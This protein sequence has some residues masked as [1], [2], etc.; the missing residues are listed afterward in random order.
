MLLQ[1]INVMKSE[2]ETLTNHT[3]KVRQL[4]VFDV[5]PQGLI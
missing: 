3:K 1:C 5:P 4:R 2:T